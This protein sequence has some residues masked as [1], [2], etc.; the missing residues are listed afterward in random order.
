MRITKLKID[1]EVTKSIINIILRDLIVKNGKIGRTSVF[2]DDA[3]TDIV[4]IHGRKFRIKVEDLPD[5]NI[6]ECPT[7]ELKD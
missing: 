7:E 4:T 3:Y 5:A 1:H 6:L 2:V